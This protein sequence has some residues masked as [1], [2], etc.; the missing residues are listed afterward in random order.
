[1]S[2]MVELKVSKAGL[3]VNKFRF[4]RNLGLN[5]VENIAFESSSSPVI[6]EILLLLYHLI[7]QP[8]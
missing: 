6:G 1:M 4:C 8:T 2:L 5:V 3:I 7:N